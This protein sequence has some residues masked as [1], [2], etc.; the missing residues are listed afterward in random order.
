LVEERFHERLERLPEERRQLVLDR[1][2]RLIRDGIDEDRALFEALRQEFARERRIYNPEEIASP[3]VS[4]DVPHGP[5]GASRG[6]R[7]GRDPLQAT[8]EPTPGPQGLWRRSRRTRGRTTSPSQ[9]PAKRA[10]ASAERRRR[11]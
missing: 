1:A 3:D 2:E 6:G 5:D 10:R 8:Q 4:F 9:R 7:D 11:G